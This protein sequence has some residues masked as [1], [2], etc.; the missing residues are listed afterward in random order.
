MPTRTLTVNLADFRREEL[1]NQEIVVRLAAGDR[2]PAEPPDPARLITDTPISVWTDRTGQAE[3][4][5]LPTT[6]LDG[7]NPYIATVPGVG[8]V[9]F[10]MPDSD[11]TLYAILQGAPGTDLP[12][13]QLP[14]PAGV[15]VQDGDTVVALSDVWATGRY[16][17]VQPTAPSPTA[18]QDAIWVNT[19]LTPPSWNWWD[20]T[21]WQAFALQPNSANSAHI[22]P[23]SLTEADFASGAVSTRVL[24]DGAVTAPKL[25]ADSTSAQ[26]ALRTRINAEE[27]GHDH[28]TGGIALGDDVVTPGMLAADQPAQKQ[29]FRDRLDVKAEVADWAETANPD[30]LPA[31]K[32]PVLDGRTHLQAGSVTGSQLA[33]DS[34]GDPQLATAVQSQLVPGGGAINEVLMKRTAADHDDQWGLVNRPNIHADVLDRLLPGGGTQ[35]QVLKKQSG[36]D[37]DADWEAEAAADDAATWAEQNNQDLIP[38]AK[39]PVIPRDKLPAEAFT[40]YVKEASF[41][42]TLANLG[43]AN[44]GRG[45]DRVTGGGGTANP[46]TWVLDGNTLTLLAFEQLA[47]SG[48]VSIKVAGTLPSNFRERVWIVEAADGYQDILRMATATRYRREPGDTTYPAGLQQYQEI[49]WNAQ[50]L[51]ILYNRTAGSTITLSIATS[52]GEHLDDEVAVWARTSNQAELPLA[53]IPVLDGTKIGTGAVSAGEIAEDAVTPAALQADTDAQKEAIRNRIGIPSPGTSAD[54][55]KYLQAQQTGTPGNMEDVIGLTWLDDD[56]IEIASADVGGI[57]YGVDKGS[58]VNPRYGVDWLAQPSP[59]LRA[60]RFLRGDLQ[61]AEPPMS[62]GGAGGQS[63]PTSRVQFVSL[64]RW[65]GTAPS[66]SELTGANLPTWGTD[67]WSNIPSGWAAP[68]AIS[69]VGNRYRADFVATWNQTTSSFTLST[70]SITEETGFNVEYTDNPDASP[71]STTSNRTSTSTHWRQRDPNTGHWPVIWNALYSGPE[72]WTVLAS[73]PI[74]VTS[75]T[76]ARI[77]T[78][79]QPIRTRDLRFLAVQIDIRNPGLNQTDISGSFIIQPWNQLWPAPANDTTNNYISGASFVAFCGP[80]EIEVISSQGTLPSNISAGASNYFGAKWK[81]RGNTATGE[82]QSVRFHEWAA[83]GQSGYITFLHR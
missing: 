69:G 39:L 23:N 52:P 5:L 19:S 1:D 15:G 9:R 65:S 24:A 43:A 78:F 34:V 74:G 4:A 64:W 17:W 66:T 82:L 27:A 44:E 40:Q 46:D 83:T 50:S 73:V 38:A 48:E 47:A 18:G 28:G 21:A 25:A 55:N 37:G 59:A 61:W 75:K 2:T 31:S 16:I 12:A 10:R 14:N 71:L 13:Q 77:V 6:E 8:T 3:I 51:D 33:D 81:F 26:Q 42:I 30:D 36:V 49:D 63:D 41:T 62:M 67:G 80:A 58:S 68:A 54:V 11:T 20:G 29:A 57:P 56:H 45:F 32:I 7:R 53:K 72:N 76:M 60:A 22:A 35:G 79:T 70:P